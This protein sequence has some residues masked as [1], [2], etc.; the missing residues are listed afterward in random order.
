MNRKWLAIAIA[1]LLLAT[2]SLLIA[3]GDEARGAPLYKGT[4][5]AGSD[6]W[7]AGTLGAENI[8]L[9][10]VQKTTLSYSVASGGVFTSTAGEIFEIVSVYYEVKTNF[11]CTGDD[12]T[13]T[14]GDGNDADGFINAADANLQ[15]TFADYTGAPAGWGGLDGSAPKG[16]YLVGGSQII[17]GAETIDYAIGG[18][19]PAAGSV[20]VYVV[21]RR[22]Q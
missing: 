6:D 3:C 18:T 19:S 21:Y 4:F 8:I 14:V 20:D 15:T 9:P 16:A 22:L 11:D 13:L 17:D 1:L 2:G 5:V 10:S 7:F 12:C